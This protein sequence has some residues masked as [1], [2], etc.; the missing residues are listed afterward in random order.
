MKYCALELKAVEQANTKGGGQGYE[1][2]G[3]VAVQC[4]HML[5]Q[6]NGVGDLQKGERY[7]LVSCDL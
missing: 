7:L 1:A 3:V 5:I 6:G 2:S 4:R